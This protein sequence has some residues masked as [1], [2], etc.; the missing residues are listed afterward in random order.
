M[1]FSSFDF[2]MMSL[3]LLEARKGLYTTDPNP[4]VGCV[5]VNN[6]RVIGR[7]WHKQAGGPHAEVEALRAVGE[8]ARGADCYVTLEPCSHHGKTGPC[9]EALVNAGVKKVIIA[10]VD[11]NPEV[12]GSG[13]RR[14][15]KAGIT[16]VTGCLEAEA[17]ELNAGFFNRMRCGSPLVRVKM[18]TSLD[19][20]TALANGVSKWI[21]GPDARLDV[22]RLRAR[23]SAILTGSG[24]LLADNPSLTVRSAEVLAQSHGML[25]QP[26]RVVL[27][28]RGCSTPEKY[29]YADPEKPF[30]SGSSLIM[31][32][33]KSMA[34]LQHQRFSANTEIVAMPVDS[35]G[36]I[37]LETV[38]K[39]LG[40]RHC[41]ELLVEAGATLAGA[42]LREKLADELW[43]YQA[44]KV[45][46]NAGRG[47]FALPVFAGLDEVPEFSLID[48]RQVGA[49]I[50]MILR[51]K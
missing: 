30:A 24:T 41:N 21:T 9:A 19:G 22:Q 31:T 15:N 25:R 50:R 33:Q 28:G 20:R 6:G 23:S 12:S 18:A 42:F 4:R 10:A 48:L 26:L 35:K 8:E 51:V 29:V 7:G 37:K 14:L 3:A 27:D 1:S 39:E 16:T 5:I 13:I 44:A 38:L 11:P 49:D 43:L 34:K 17:T 47:A 32:Q 2:N 46:G 40:K 36:Q 45:I